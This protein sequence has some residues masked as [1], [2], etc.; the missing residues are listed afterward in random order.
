[1]NPTNLWLIPAL[2]LLA[3]GL[4][5]LAKQ[6]QRRFA[7]TLA[8]GAMAVALLLSCAAFL[9]ALQASGKGDTVR[10][11]CSFTWV[12]FGDTQLEAGDLRLGW[13]LDP[14]GAVMN[15]AS[16][17]SSASCDREAR[18]RVLKDPGLSA[19]LPSSD[20]FLQTLTQRLGIKR[21]AIKQDGINHRPVA[22][23][24]C[25]ITCDPAV[26]G[27]RKRPFSQSCLS[28]RR[29]IIPIAF[30]KKPVQNDRLDLGSLDLSA[31]CAPEQA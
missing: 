26:R 12:H 19:A 29:L 11:V 4:T 10:Q 31:E 23:K 1:M 9:Q 5:A 16:E 14:L 7:A 6:R 2:P 20:L 18:L 13:V 28:P 27:V 25:E 21:S 15:D 17:M 24:F 22:Q 8:I 3:A 30:G